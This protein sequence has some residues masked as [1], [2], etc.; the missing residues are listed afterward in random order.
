MK[1]S[2]LI[3]LIGSVSSQ[4]TTKPTTLVY[5]GPE[6]VDTSMKTNLL[7]WSVQAVPIDFDYSTAMMCKDAADAYAVADL[8]TGVKVDFK[9]VFELWSGRCKTLDECV[10]NCEQTFNWWAAESGY[11]CAMLAFDTTEG[12]GEC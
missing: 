11:A 2:S 10:A 1:Y 5:D 3:A 7:A 12:S 4:S 6:E 9:D 8:A